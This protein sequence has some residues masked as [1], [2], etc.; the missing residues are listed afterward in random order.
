MISTNPSKNEND[1]LEVMEAFKRQSRLSTVD[2][3]IR[4][5]LYSVQKHKLKVMAITLFMVVVVLE[6]QAYSRI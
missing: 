3:D 1:R 6:N 5:H 2:F 4:E